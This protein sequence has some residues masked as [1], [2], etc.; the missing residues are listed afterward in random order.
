[1][2]SNLPPTSGVRVPAEEMHPFVESLFLAAGMSGEHATLMARLLIRMDLRGVF[3]HGTRSAPGYIQMIRRGRVNPRPRIRVVTETATTRVLDGDGGMGHIPCYE[4]ARW[5]VD[6]ARAFGTAAV[7]T[8]N[9]FHFGGASKYTLLALESDCIGIA[10]SSHRYNLAPEA[11][12]TSV[13]GASP[14]SVALPAGQQPPLVLD[15]GAGLLPWDE[16]LYNR[17]PFS[18]Y[19]DLGIAAINRALGGV[20]PGIYLPPFCPPESP[21]ESNQGS[22]IAVF[23][24]ACFMPIEEFRQQMDRF[25]GAARAMRPFPGQKSAELPGGLE[26][27]CQVDWAREGIPISPEHEASLTALA[28]ELEVTTPFEPYQHTR[29]EHAPV[30]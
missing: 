18:Y 10:I 28:A 16:D 29:F 14:I 3:S 1:M 13:N 8:R 19:K 5:A 12:I 23:S 15:M 20:L 25:I 6:Q 9:H 26:H 22:F 17:L 11:P 7:T 21:W 4:G 27:Q 2:G 24:V 30:P